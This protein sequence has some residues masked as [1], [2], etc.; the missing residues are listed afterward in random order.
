MSNLTTMSPRHKENHENL[1]PVPLASWAKFEAARLHVSLNAVFSRKKRGKYPGFRFVKHNARRVDVLLPAAQAELLLARRAAGRARRCECGGLCDGDHRVCARCRGIE[2]QMYS[3]R[4][5]L[6][7]D[8]GPGHDA[9]AKYVDLFSVA[10]SGR[11]RRAL[12]GMW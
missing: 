6:G 11:R 2:A 3:G 8:A 9:L 12:G 1:C 7:P 5:Q 4:F 10:D